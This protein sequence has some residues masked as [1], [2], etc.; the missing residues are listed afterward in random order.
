MRDHAIT[1]TSRTMFRSPPPSSRPAAGLSRQ[2]WKTRTARCCA[3]NWSAAAGQ[4]GIGMGTGAPARMR[5][6]LVFHN[7]RF[8]DTPPAAVAIEPASGGATLVAL[9][10]NSC[11]F[12]GEEVL[13]IDSPSQASGLA[14]DLADRGLPSFGGS[15][16]PMLRS[17]SMIA[18]ARRHSPW[19]SMCIRLASSAA[20]IAMSPSRFVD[21]E[22][23][24][25]APGRSRLRPG[26]CVYMFYSAVQEACPFKYYCSGK[27]GA[28]KNGLCTIWL[29][30]Y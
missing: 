27:A 5:R 9:Y 8:P 14:P 6:R 4:V 28:G 11:V 7:V 15:H 20:S 25:V 10:T 2:A 26:F 1:P 24:T 16:N 19:F 12:L 18:S 13:L 17:V 21:S 30:Y 29:D 23:V 3:G 22:D